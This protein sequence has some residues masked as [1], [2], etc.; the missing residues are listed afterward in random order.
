LP[1][2]EVKMHKQV[3]VFIR[4]GDKWCFRKGGDTWYV[5]LGDPVDDVTLFFRN[6]TLEEFFNQIKEALNEQ[7]GKSI[8]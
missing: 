7:Q 5:W 8:G 1:L 6:G 3:N 2:K 4:P